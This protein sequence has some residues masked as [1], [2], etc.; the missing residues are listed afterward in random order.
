MSTQTTDA[1][2]RDQNDREAHQDRLRGELAAEL[3]SDGTW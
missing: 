2:W 1:S 3:A